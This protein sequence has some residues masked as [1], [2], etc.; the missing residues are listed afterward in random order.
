[1]AEHLK[2]ENLAQ[3]G[4]VNHGFFTR[5]GGVSSGLYA[6]LNTGRGSKD[7][8]QAIGENRSRVR[9]ALG[10]E[11]LC[12][13]AQIHSAKVQTVEMPWLPSD[14]PEAD[15]LVTNRS[16]LALG[17]LTA[18]CVPVLFADSKAGVIGA[19]HAGWKGAIGGVVGNTVTAMEKLGAEKSQILA[20]IGPAIEQDS[21]Q[22]DTLFRSNFLSQDAQCEGFFTRDMSS[23]SHYR[24]DL[25]KYVLLQCQRAGIT[26]VE[27]LPHN[28][29][30]EEE[31]FYSYRRSCHRNE[32]D[33]GRQ[34][35]AIMLKG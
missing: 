20:A 7:S 30:T 5:K 23:P 16:G 29:Y 22:V 28:T 19:A 21:Y 17:I 25:K 1:M 2:A 24:F 8:Q 34:V 27:T 4:A 18:D 33:Y 6:S 3:I 26:N 11:A 31:S 14:M 10:A 15:A 12:S 13:L 9:K 32:E 35:S